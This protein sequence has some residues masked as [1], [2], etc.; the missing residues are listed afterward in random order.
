MKKKATEMSRRFPLEVIM[1]LTR[2]QVDAAA[3]ALA[4]LR[5][6]ETAASSTLQMLESCRLD[7]QARLER[8]SQAGLGSEQWRNYYDFLGKLDYA[9]AQQQQV[10][11]QC[12][13][14]SRTGLE[15]WQAARAKLKSFEVL[16]ERHNLGES[17]R[18]ARNEQKDQDEHSASSHP[19]RLQKSS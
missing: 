3:A 5:A 9:L 4:Q 1:D 16:L 13:Q 18:E 19:H 7:Y 8:S 11:A 15:A 12:A 10:L 17:R 14:Q 2:K 6:K